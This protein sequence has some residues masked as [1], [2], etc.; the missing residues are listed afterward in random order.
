MFKRLELENDG[1]VTFEYEG[2]NLTAHAGDTVAAALLAAGEAVFRS[3][4]GKGVERGPFCMMG[5]CFDCLMEIDGMPNTQACQVVV[6]PGMKVARQS[7]AIELAL[8]DE[9]DAR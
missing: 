6:R 3:T 5:V 9:G 1:A 7:G 8:N 2:R 4:P